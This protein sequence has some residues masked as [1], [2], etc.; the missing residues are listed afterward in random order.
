MKK[1]GEKMRVL[2]T[3]AGG[4]IGREALGLLL[5]KSD[6]FEIR[7]FDLDNLKNRE[8]FDR[9]GEK[10]EVFFGDIS[11]PED[12]IAPVRDVDAV[13]HMVSVIPPLASERPDLVDTV[14]VGGTRNLVRA[15]EEYSPQA[16]LMFASSVAIY[17]DRFLDPFINITDPENPVS[18]DHYGE[19]KVL[20][21]QAVRNSKLQWTIFRLSAIM[22]AGNH[23][24]SGL[25]FRMPLEQLFEIC[26]P[27]DTARAF[28]NG[29]TELEQLTGKIF[30]L[31]GGPQCTTTYRT[32]LENNFRIY[33]LG[34]FDFPLHA[35]ATQNY[36]CGYFEDGDDLEN[37]VHFRR[38]TLADYYDQVRESIPGIQRV[39]TQLTSKLVKSYLLHLSEPYQ[40][41]KQRDVEA[42]RFYFREFEEL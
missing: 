4:H 34:E 30:N 15:M 2:L 14:N 16:F 41:V 11:R 26:T 8:Y 18:D 31:G 20:M 13:I 23:T 29:L 24:M 35:F 28:V 40:A 7:V 10:L 3:G 21:E 22:G 36:H 38:D 32:F 17:G 33:G 42:M 39:A 6:L 25:M 5:A 1:I 27:R 19:G 37:I 9:F 12:L